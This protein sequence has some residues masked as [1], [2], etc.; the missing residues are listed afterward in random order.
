MHKKAVI[1]N[2][3][4]VYGDDVSAEL[5]KPNDTE[6]RANREK[7][8]TDHRKDLLQRNDVEFYKAYPEQAKNLSDDTRR[9]L[10]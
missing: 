6:A 5:I 7:M 4:I 2:G 8:R 1:R 3:H 10:S 9:L